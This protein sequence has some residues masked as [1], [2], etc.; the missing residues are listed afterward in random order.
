MSVSENLESAGLRM[1][2]GTDIFAEQTSLRHVLADLAEDKGQAFVH[3]YQ[4]S[5][6][7]ADLDAALQNYHT[8]VDLSK[9]PLAKAGRLRSLATLY[10]DQY[11]K[12]GDLADLGAALQKFQEAGDLGH[13]DRAGCLLNLAICFMFRYQRL[14]NPN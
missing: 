9:E 4:T 14:E 12:L 3:K 6:N 1:M 10:R 8:A 5:G 2:Q 7:L 11:Q 13:L